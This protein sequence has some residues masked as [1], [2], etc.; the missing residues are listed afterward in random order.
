MYF[1]VK[2]K[3][4][5]FAAPSISLSIFRIAN[6]PGVLDTFPNFIFR[7]ESATWEKFVALG[8]L[9]RFF[10]NVGEMNQ[11]EKIPVSGMRTWAA[12]PSRYLKDGN[13]AFITFE[14]VG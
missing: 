3:S 10:K 6:S 11:I 14:V 7:L 5:A 2:Q 1:D 4:A 12:R 9:T 8:G 13:G